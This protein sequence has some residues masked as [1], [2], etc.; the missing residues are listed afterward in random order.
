MFFKSDK[1]WV[2][3]IG[4]GLL[5]SIL[6]TVY[7]HVPI[8][9]VYW[10]NLAVLFGAFISLAVF[11]HVLNDLCDL[12]SDR[13]AGKRNLVDTVGKNAALVILFGAT[14]L[15]LVL[16]SI[17][18]NPLLLALAGVQIL[19]NLMYSVR[20]IRMKERGILAIVITGFYERTLPYIMIAV[21]LVE[22]V[23]SDT[24]L[25]LLVYLTWSFLWEAR[26]FITGQKADR[27][28]DE[29]SQQKTISLVISDKVLNSFQ[30]GLF[31]FEVI[32]LFLWMVRF[33]NWWVVATV[34]VPVGLYFYRRENGTL[35][36]KRSELFKV[37]DDSY[38]LS[39]PV[40]FGLLAVFTYSV[41]IWPILVLLLIAFDNHLRLL[42]VII[43]KNVDWQ[44]WWRWVTFPFRTAS[45]I[46]NW[47]I[48]Y[49]RKWILKWPEE[50][51][52][53]KHYAKHLDDERMNQSIEKKDS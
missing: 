46:F 3:K 43:A 49:F 39:F 13:L 14:G 51:N 36:T 48:Y 45:L 18:E 52:W 27:L 16:I 15:A 9:S 40:L 33:A 20:P 42:S 35:P 26:N 1:W 11:G 31:L 4:G 19:L 50:R 47:S 5:T 29:Q 17:L 30:W 41:D 7:Y 28:L 8:T 23:N 25:L 12:Q 21:L 53:G 34:C 44:R 6:F 38:N 2:Y 24:Y 22:H 37:I 10:C 32:L